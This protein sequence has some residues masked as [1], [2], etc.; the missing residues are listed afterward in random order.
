VSGGYIDI[1]SVTVTATPNNNYA[2]VNWTEN[3]QEQSTS[4]S[5][6]FIPVSDR[7]LTANFTF[8]LPTVSIPSISPNRGTFRKKVTVRISDSTSG[9]IIYYTTNGNDP[10]S[11]SAV[12]HN[13]F[14]LRGRGM[15][16]VKAM[17][18][19]AGYIDS[20]IARVN[21]TIHH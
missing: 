6:T 15:K 16:T 14:K 1:S 18:V 5:Y 2:F 8:N 17:G 7:T 3:G 13:A 19:K 4:A 12:Y 20:A 10:T 11:S 21:L 9:A